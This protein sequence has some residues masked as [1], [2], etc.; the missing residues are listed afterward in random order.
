MRKILAAVFA[1]VLTAV[2]VYAGPFGSGG[3][4]SS[5]DQSGS[6]DWKF[7]SIN[8]GADIPAAKSFSTSEAPMTI[9]GITPFCWRNGSHCM[10]GEVLAISLLMVASVAPE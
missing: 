7:G 1:I 9:S 4:S 6:T 10:L 2:A 5:H 8:I 3:G